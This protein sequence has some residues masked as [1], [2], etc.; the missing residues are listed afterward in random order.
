MKRIQDIMTA[1][2]S[3][4]P[5]AQQAKISSFQTL[6]NWKEIVG[7]TLAAVTEPLKIEKEV[8]LIRVEE[9]AWRSELQFMKPELLRKIRENAGIKLKD[10][11]F[12]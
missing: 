12:V 6:V 9:A 11:K 4:M 5:A 7:E 1:L 2:L 10:V 3:E 8:L